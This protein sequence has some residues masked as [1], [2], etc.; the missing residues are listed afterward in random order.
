MTSAELAAWVQAGGVLLAMWASYRTVRGQER[1][2]SAERAKDEAHLVS[3]WLYQP[4]R[5][6]DGDG[7][8]GWVL[9]GKVRNRSKITAWCVK[10]EAIGADGEPLPLPPLVAPAVAPEKDW[11]L[12]WVSDHRPD[13]PGGPPRPR[14][15]ARRR[16]PPARPPVR[17]GDCG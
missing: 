8:T 2:R 10:A 5:L 7:E 6:H 15:R 16:R 12:R 13:D 14:R 11:H 1:R 17:A 9:T 4:Q 3:G